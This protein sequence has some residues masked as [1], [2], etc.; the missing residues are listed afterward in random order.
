MLR[1]SETLRGLGTK[2]PSDCCWRQIFNLHR[3]KTGAVCQRWWEDELS[4]KETEEKSL[5]TLSPSLFQAWLRAP[6]PR[7]FQMGTR[8]SSGTVFLACATIIRSASNKH[9]EGH[10][11]W[12][13]L[14]ELPRRSS[15]LIKYVFLNPKLNCLPPEAVWP[16][17][18]PAV[19]VPLHFQH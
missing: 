1:I 2:R 16:K 5:A 9:V 15:P 13:V 7:L 8:P 3:E 11:S 6:C 10:L 17:S 4:G 19:G 12:S 14:G 18:P